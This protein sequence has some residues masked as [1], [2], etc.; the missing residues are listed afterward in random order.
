MIVKLFD[1]GAVTALFLSLAV[2]PLALFAVALIVERRRLKIKDQYAAFIYGDVALAVSVAAGAAAWGA[3]TAADQAGIEVAQW[4]FLV[5][6]F[7]TAAG[8][9]IH[10]VR[11]GTYTRSQALSPTKI[12]HQAA[13]I[14]LLTAAV[15]CALIV[16]CQQWN[17]APWALLLA[18]AGVV[19]WLAMMGFDQKHPKEAHINF[20]WSRFSPDPKL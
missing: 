20:S 12:W 13:I 7:I 8:Q 6:G 15:G 11:S 18:I 1:E 19:V 3:S 9:G 2:S 10:E 5:F 4:F 17:T 16:T 14:P